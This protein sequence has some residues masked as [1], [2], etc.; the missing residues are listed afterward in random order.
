MGSG[1]QRRKALK[2]RGPTPKAEDRVYHKAYKAKQAAARKP[3]TSPHRPT[4][5][6]KGPI[7]E[8][9]VTG[10]NSVLEALRSNVPAK[11]LFVATKIEVDARYTL[12]LSNVNNL[13]GFEYKN[14]SCLVMAGVR[15]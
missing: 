12:G 15:F 9:L 11:T 2:G 13:S 5:A 10:R 1:G 6:G 8:D 7:K 14:R 4:R 3:Q